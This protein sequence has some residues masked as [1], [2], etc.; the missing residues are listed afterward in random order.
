MVLRNVYIDEFLLTDSYIIQMSF[1]NGFIVLFSLLTKVSYKFAWFC[2]NK[3]NAFLLRVSIKNV[4]EFIG[5][6]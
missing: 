3:K 4:W 6:K 1:K 2:E 5:G